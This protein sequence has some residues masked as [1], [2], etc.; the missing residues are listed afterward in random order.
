MDVAADLYLPD[1]FASS[2]K[3][4]AVV[5]AHPGSS[6]KEQTA[7]IYASKLAAEGFVTIAVN[8]SYQGDSGGEPRYIEIPGERMEDLRCAID[9]LVS[10][11]YVDAERIGALGVCAGGG[12]VVNLAM[13][14]RRI[15]AVGTSAGANIGA[16]YRGADIDATI[17]S[18]EE[19]GRQ[20]TVEARG[21]EAMIVPWVV[22][23][24]KDSE[25]VDLRGAYEYYCTPR[26]K[27]P[28]SPNKLRY[29][30]MADVMAFD[31]LNM[32]DRYLTQPLMIIVGD[33]KG[34]FG[35]YDT[36]YQIYEKAAS[37]HKSLHV[38]KDACHYDLYDKPE[39]VNE[40]VALL[41]GFYREY[42]R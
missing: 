33:R 27:H 34:A 42:L 41:S 20:R 1:G 39:A 40:A 9:Y 16:L 31:P 32:I 11:P 6:C 30:S 35:S 21:G 4:P 25:D 10:L 29:T 19:I 8:A 15:K 3:Y 36:G 37:E 5:I 2:N 26:G 12:Y 7:G 38:I 24:Q 28:N 13:T 18:L 14:E 23:A 22:D 17:K